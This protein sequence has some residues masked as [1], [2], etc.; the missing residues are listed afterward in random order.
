MALQKKLLHERIPVVVIAILLL[1]IIGFVILIFLAKPN[2]QNELNA[3][4]I[5]NEMTQQTLPKYSVQSK[6]E[7]TQYLKVN[8]PQEYFRTFDLGDDSGRKYQNSENEP[9]IVY[10]ILE[11]NGEEIKLKPY[12]KQNNN[13]N[14]LGNL[15]SIHIESLSKTEKKFQLLES[16]DYIVGYELTRPEFETDHL[17][18]ELVGNYAM[19][20]RPIN[21]SNSI[22]DPFYIMIARGEKPKSSAMFRDG[23]SIATMIK[24]GKYVVKYH[25]T[26][27]QNF[28]KLI[29]RGSPYSPNEA[30]N[31]LER[32]FILTSTSN[33]RQILQ[34]SRSDLESFVRLNN[35]VIGLIEKNSVV[36]QI[37]D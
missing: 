4:I 28:I 8:L 11:I 31:F 20:L 21:F 26:Y 10:A 9:F 15:I 34:F 35:E 22:Y 25:V 23:F 27:S 24:N 7:P 18:A 33:P 6:L 1:F 2:H 14:E 19:L 37:V 29:R 3:R 13:D 36:E 16:K 5:Q 17:Q 32:L 30:T 12:K